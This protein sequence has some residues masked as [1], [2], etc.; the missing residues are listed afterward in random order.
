[1]RLAYDVF[2]WRD[3]A[4]RRLLYDGALHALEQHIALALPQPAGVETWHD[5]PWRLFQIAQLAGLTAGDVVAMS[6]DT[7]AAVLSRAAAFDETMRRRVWHE[8]YERR[9]R[10]RVLR[11]VADNLARPERERA[12]ADADLTLQVICCFD[13]REEGFR[14]HIEAREP[15]AE[16]YGNAGFFGVPI[17]YRGLDDPADA[18]L[19]PVVVTPANRVE[20]APVPDAKPLAALRRA[21]RRRLA[22]FV[23]RFEE[24]SRGLVRAAVLTPLFGLVTTVPWVLKTVAPRFEA[25]LREA[26]ARAAFPSPPTALT[27]LRPDDAAKG[28]G[29]PTGFTVVE[30]AQRVAAS[31]ENVGLT[32]RFARLVV[33][34]G[35]GGTSV[36]NPHRSAYDCGACGGRH[37][38][39]NARLV[40]RLANDPAVREA[41]VAR[42]IHIPDTTCFVGG[43]HDTTTDG[44]ALY[45]T[46]ALPASHAADLARAVEVLDD[47]RKMSAHERCRKFESAPY[48]PSPERALRHVEGRAAD[49]SQARPELGHVTI[50]SGVVGRRSLTR[51][52]FFD[53]RCFLISYD[54]DGDPEGRVLERIL[55]AAGPVGAGINLEYLFS[56]T[57]NDRY[58]AGTKLPHNP[59]GLLGVMDG[60]VSDLRTGLPK[61]MIE[62][63][64]PV[65]LLLVVEATPER[66][67]AL[68]ARQA[69][70]KE[71][72]VNE[73]V[74]LVSLDPG[75]GAMKRFTRGAFEPWDPSDEPPTPR[76]PSSRDWYRG[77]IDFL[78]PAIV[79]KGGAS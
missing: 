47:A 25:R 28:A 43:E 15:G 51:G 68:A 60:A 56:C 48:D 13:D 27:A 40:A 52:L 36:N 5:A 77:Q 78:P 33:V 9:Y 7:R 20:E 2:A 58:G 65:R 69:E 24:A 8:A 73:W 57:D 76:A 67:R 54:P 30:A 55:Q 10:Q 19:C 38:G 45:D 59:V 4:K 66:L 6:A 62:I 34:L 21:R 50:A 71:L 53:R 37:G 44:V 75:T 26:S 14:R 12:V 3:V 32:R 70:V 1:M 41:L 72:V 79:A 17:D 49:I 11:A 35:H 16:T 29:V 39:P 22:R 46:D 18:P 61:Q 64:E 42:G 63:H 31:L 23:H 74:Q